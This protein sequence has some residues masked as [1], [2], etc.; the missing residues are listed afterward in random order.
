MPTF[1]RFLVLLVYFFII[2]SLCAQSQATEVTLWQFGKGRL[3]E[4]VVTEPLKA[5]GTAPYGAATFY[6]YQALNPTV[7]TTNDGAGS[8]TTQTVTLTTPRTIIASASGWVEP[9]VNDEIAC[10]FIDPDFG[11]C[12]DG[13]STANSGAP[14]PQVF[15]VAVTQAFAGSSS[16][17]SPPVVSTSTPSSAPSSTSN[18]NLDQNTTGKPSSLVLGAIVGGTVGGLAALGIGVAVI[19]LLYRRR[20]IRQR[21]QWEHDDSIIAGAGVVRFNTAPQVEAS[22]SNTSTASVGSRKIRD[23]RPPAVHVQH[24]SARA[25]VT[26]TDSVPDA[27]AIYRTMVEINER[28]RLLEAEGSVRHEEPP[29]TYA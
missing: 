3:L 10:R 24:K 29:P 14:T 12:V 1:D 19:L 25:Q 20:R 6:L 23:G 28:L 15:Q 16:I 21:R 5:L 8:L 11:A 26:T 27:Q 7:I 2:F 22:M 18:A 17:T 13:T 4:A 9:F